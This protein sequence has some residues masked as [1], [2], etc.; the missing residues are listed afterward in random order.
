GLVNPAAADGFAER[1]LVLLP[2]EPEVHFNS[3]LLFRPDAQKALLVKAF[4]GELMKVRK[5]VVQPRPAKAGYKN[6]AWK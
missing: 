5:I 2:F 4:T 3:V 1:G 6:N